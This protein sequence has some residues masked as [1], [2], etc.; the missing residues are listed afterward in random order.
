MKII[1]PYADIEF[2]DEFFVL[3]LGDESTDDWSELCDTAKAALLVRATLAI[4]LLD[5]IKRGFRGER[6][7]PA[8]QLAFPRNGD[9][10]VPEKVKMAC[11]LEA[12]A[13]ADEE[14]TQRRDLRRQGV[15]GMSVGNASENYMRFGLFDSNTR[16]RAQVDF[17]ESLASQ[18]AFGLMLEFMNVSGV[19][20]IL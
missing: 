17:S 19:H 20:R 1:E 9:R 3:Y 15:S 4:D 7:Q 16:N 18:E 12:L 8:Q 5:N 13:L 11:A 6:T 2:A 14:G 10:F